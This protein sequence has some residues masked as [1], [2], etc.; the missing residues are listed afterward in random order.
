MSAP[1]DVAGMSDE[2]VE[3]IAQMALGGNLGYNLGPFLLA[4]LFDALAWGI[5]S[6]QYMTWWQ[7]SRE[8]ERKYLRYLTH[9]LTLAAFG[10]TVMLIAYAMQNFV[11]NFGEFKIFMNIKWAQLFPFIDACLAAPVQA[12]YAERSF[13]LNNRNYFLLCLI[14]LLMAGSLS[15]TIWLLV[16]CQALTNLLQAELM[17]PQLRSW[18]VITL[19]TDLVITTSIGWGLWQSR[20]GWSDTDALVKKLLMIT[21][22]T[23]LGPTLL[24][25]AFVIEFSI[26]PPASIGIFFE[27]LIPKAYVIGYLATLNSRYNLRREGRGGSSQRDGGG[28]LQKPNTYALGSHNLQQATVRVDTDTYVESYAM[29]PHRSGINRT[30]VNT[31][32]N[33]LYELKEH[34]DTESAENLDY[35]QNLS[36]RNLNTKDSPV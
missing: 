19:A 22:E 12:F 29:Q 8:T 7:Y 1:V 33:D 30:G 11:Y 25:L 2:Q 34:D 31:T 6:Q 28:G 4:S 17:T 13:R 14:A 27:L 35:A 10:Y 18:Q 24:M 5:V 20:T 36:K 23:Q 3:A 9:V 16:S 26:T 15:T 32:D 21:W